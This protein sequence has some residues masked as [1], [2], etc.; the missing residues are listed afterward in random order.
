MPSTL[1]TRLKHL[2]VAFSIAV[3]PSASLLS[4]K[5]PEAEG[6]LSAACRTAGETFEID[7]MAVVSTPAGSAGFVIDRPGCY[8]VTRDLVVPD[9]DYGFLIR[10]NHVT[11]DLQNHLVSDPLTRST[12]IRV[13]GSFD[14]TIIN[15]SLKGGLGGVIATIEPSSAIGSRLTIRGMSITSTFPAYAGIDVHKYHDVRI[16]SNVIV[17]VDRGVVVRE[18]PFIVMANNRIEAKGAGVQLFRTLS[19]RIHGNIIRASAPLSADTSY[20]IEDNVLVSREAGTEALLLRGPMNRVLRN[21]IDAKAS[22]S[23]ISLNG[24]MNVVRGNRIVSGQDRGI[25]VSSWGNVIEDNRVD[26][27]TESSVSVSS[28]GNRVLGNWV[29]AR[30]VGFTVSGASNLLEQNSVGGRELECGIAFEG[31][32]NVHRHNRLRGT[33][34]E[35]C[36]EPSTE[37]T[38]SVTGPW[39][40]G[41]GHGTTGADRAATSRVVGFDSEC[42]VGRER[43]ILISGLRAMETAFGTTGLVIDEPGYYIVTKDLLVPYDGNGFR[44]NS[45]ILV[46]APDVVIDLDH[47]TIGGA[48]EILVRAL[49]EGSVTLRSGLLAGGDIG[50]HATSSEVKRDQARLVLDD[51]KILWGGNTDYQGL[52]MHNVGHIQIRRSVIEGLDVA[53]GVMGPTTGLIEDSF[54]DASEFGFYGL[55][56]N[57]GVIRRSHFFG[58]LGLWVGSGNTLVE[59]TIW[60]VRAPALMAGEENEVLN[61]VIVGAEDGVRILEDDNLIRGNIIRASSGTGVSLMSNM[62]QV[63]ANVINDSLFGIEVLGEDNTIENNLL[64]RATCGLVLERET[65][66]IFS[67]NVVLDAW[68]GVCGIAAENGGGNILPAPVCGNGL[69]SIEEACDGTDIPGQTCQD[70]GFG[71]GTLGCNQTCDGFDTSYC[72]TCGDGRREGHEVCDGVD[73]PAWS[74]QDFGFW[75]G[76]LSCGSTCRLDLSR[77]FK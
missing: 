15:G 54:I 1:L 74:C 3:A 61:N 49:L 24:S 51:M 55:S 11:L 31:S 46:T 50:L 45:G 35:I 76:I 4:T 18:N 64:V 65:G 56:F 67:E 72:S 22:R 41:D 59:N 9:V 69:R 36:G 53:M 12:I 19:G 28:F 43:E 27:G 42:L 73:M 34:A 39:Q 14:A 63:E 75:G 29:A 37:G 32:G 20:V 26:G 16:L 6:A 25:D 8:V 13:M 10:A 23:A 60:G 68:E 40:G 71:Q 21:E 44:L 66:N 47:H 77:C 38:G 17:V 33:G 57:Q 58:E 30:A 5:L 70:F 62:N 48:A 52:S 2:V 7:V